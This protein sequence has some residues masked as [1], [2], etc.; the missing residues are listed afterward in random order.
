MLIK[1]PAAPGRRLV[2]VVD[3][4]PR[5][6]LMACHG[7]I[8]DHIAL[9]VR[10]AQPALAASAAEL[11]AAAHSVHRYFSVA[12]PLHI[13]DEDD[14]VRPRLAGVVAEDALRTMSE[15]H[16]IIDAELARLVPYFA[17]LAAG[18]LERAALLREHEALIDLQRALDLHLELEETRIFPA[19]EQWTPAQRSELMR[20]LRDRRRP[21]TS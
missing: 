4:D 13:A 9:A 1:S 17:E 15:Q 19:L 5:A 11:A 21:T 12:L 16:V 10:L 8:R 6:L 20:E 2:T 18:R 14:S 7:R 3:E